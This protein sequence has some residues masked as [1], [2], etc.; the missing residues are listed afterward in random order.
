MRPSDPVCAASP[1][2]E[3]D[4]KCGKILPADPSLASHMWNDP[5]VKDMLSLCPWERCAH[6]SGL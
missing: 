1:K 6:M 2:G 3:R 5:A 4:P